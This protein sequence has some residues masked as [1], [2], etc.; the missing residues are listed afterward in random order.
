M[1]RSRYF[2][3]FE[4]DCVRIGISRGIEK[5]TIARAIKRTKVGV[6]QQVNRMQDDGSLTNLPMIFVV[7]EVADWLQRSGSLK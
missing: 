5:A 6:G 7:D 2:T 4:R 1:A 3:D